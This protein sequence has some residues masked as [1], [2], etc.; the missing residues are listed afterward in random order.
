VVAAVVAA[1]VVVVVVE[2]RHNGEHHI[3]EID[4]D[5]VALYRCFFIIL[6]DFQ[7]MK[8]SYLSPLPLEVKYIAI[9]DNK[10]SF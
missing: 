9:S 2:V 3:A 7:Y 8:L 5:I 4:H 6:I 10:Y 1:V